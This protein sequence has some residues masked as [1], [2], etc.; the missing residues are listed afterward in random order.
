MPRV[1]RRTA[2][3]LHFTFYVEVPNQGERS[4]PIRAQVESDDLPDDEPEV[5]RELTVLVRRPQAAK[6]AD[7]AAVGVVRR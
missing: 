1:T 3:V 5:V 6:P 7:R 4:V 2:P